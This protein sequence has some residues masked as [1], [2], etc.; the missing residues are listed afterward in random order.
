MGSTAVCRFVGDDVGTGS[1]ARAFHSQFN[2]AILPAR[3]WMERWTG[4]WMRSVYVLYF[5]MKGLPTM[6]M[7]GV[8]D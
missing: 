3:S 5:S 7:G 6:I 8:F 4:F 2:V 1:E